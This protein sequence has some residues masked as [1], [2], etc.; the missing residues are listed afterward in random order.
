MMLTKRISTLEQRLRPIQR[1]RLYDNTPE[2]ALWFT[3]MLINDLDRWHELTAEERR[4]LFFVLGDNGFTESR[5]REFV[6]WQRDMHEQGEL[7]RHYGWH[8]E[9]HELMG[10]NDERSDVLG[11]RT[12][13]IPG[14]GAHHFF[15]GTQP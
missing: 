5:F 13:V 7:R 14:W 9:Y 2:R 12:Q 3:G 8:G 10:L 4:M 6:Q 11:H 15:D 1:D